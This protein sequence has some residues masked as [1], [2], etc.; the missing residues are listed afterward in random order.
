VGLCRN[1]PAEPRPKNVR[2]VKTDLTSLASCKAAVAAAH[3]W[4]GAEGEPA[5]PTSALSAR[6]ASDKAVCW[7]LAIEAA[8]LVAFG[9]ARKTVLTSDPSGNGAEDLRAYPVYQVSYV[10]VPG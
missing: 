9:A 6:A 10:L 7:V 1:P 8:D 2:F 3:C 5:S 4:V